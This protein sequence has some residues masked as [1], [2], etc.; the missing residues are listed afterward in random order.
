MILSFLK[1]VLLR[2]MSFSPPGNFLA[3]SMFTFLVG[4]LKL[5]SM[6]MIVMAYIECFVHVPC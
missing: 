1:S 5:T 4:L 6:M 2:S 3:C